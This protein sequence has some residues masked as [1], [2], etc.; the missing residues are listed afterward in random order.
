MS[1]FLVVLS[2]TGRES[3]AI[4]PVE[5]K[6]PYPSP[7]VIVGEDLTF[8]HSPARRPDKSA[9]SA[10]PAPAAPETQHAALSDTS[11]PPRRNYPTGDWRAR[12][13]W[14]RAATW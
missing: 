2:G 5:S 9:G 6:H 8:P 14:S 11:T 4:L 3:E 10:A 13:Q 12:A 7:S 1:R